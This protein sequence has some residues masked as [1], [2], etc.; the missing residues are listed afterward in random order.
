M[1]E[2]A[3]GNMSVQYEF[4]LDSIRAKAHPKVRPSALLT[5]TIPEISKETYSVYRL[6]CD[7][8]VKKDFP[9]SFPA[10][11]ADYLRW[12]RAMTEKQNM[13]LAVYGG[14]KH[15]CWVLF[16]RRDEETGTVIYSMDSD[17]M[18]CGEH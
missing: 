5:F 9:Q 10:A 2:T 11:L 18:T 3:N 8:S 15:V 6:M 13:N 7:G 4:D 1:S 16:V 14:P 17:E 12:M